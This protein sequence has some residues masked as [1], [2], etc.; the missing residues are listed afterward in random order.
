MS[1]YNCF[2]V[3]RQLQ[4]LDD[5]MSPKGY[6]LINGVLSGDIAEKEIIKRC[7]ILF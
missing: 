5:A 4:Y 3:Y 7:I 6:S 2:R 1:I